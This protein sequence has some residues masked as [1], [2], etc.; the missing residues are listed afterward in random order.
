MTNEMISINNSV[1]S[2][3]LE[4]FGRTD[5]PRI[6]PRAFMV[7]TALLGKSVPLLLMTAPWW[8]KIQ[9][10]TIFPG[11]IGHGSLRIDIW[12]WRE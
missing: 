11:V 1:Q 8:R 10:M 9:T 4:Y 2:A 6:S 12:L 7:G 5:W 3:V